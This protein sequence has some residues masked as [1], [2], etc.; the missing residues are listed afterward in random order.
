[1]SIV[2]STNFLAVPLT[3][4]DGR[5]MGELQ[6]SGKPHGAFTEEDEDI[7]V[8]LAQ[9]TSIAVENTLK[10]PCRSEEHTS[11]LQSRFDLVCRLLLEKKK[12]KKPHRRN[13]PQ[14]SLK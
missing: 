13:A 2:R 7:L 11:E 9:M 6:V 1:M 3:R 4:R 10:A 8:Q 14:T 12:N 5:N